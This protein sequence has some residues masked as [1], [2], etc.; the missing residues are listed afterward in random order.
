MMA[1]GLAIFLFVT[2]IVNDSRET[3]WTP[4][5]SF[6]ASIDTDVTPFIHVAQRCFLISL[7]QSRC[8]DELE[9][10]SPTRTVRVG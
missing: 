1:K 8:I 6:I 3:V 7:T 2:T 10:R 9:F 5:L 4:H